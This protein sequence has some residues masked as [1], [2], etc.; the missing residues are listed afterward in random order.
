MAALAGV[1]FST[2][3]AVVQLG[4]YAGFAQ[5]CSAVITYAGGDL[6]V[7]ARG[8]PVF[9][10]GR[11]LPAGTRFIVAQHPCVAGVRAVALAWIDMQ[12]ATSPRLNT[13]VVGLDPSPERVLPWTLERGLPEDLLLPMRVSVDRFDLPKF[14][15]GA[16]PVGQPITIG[17]QPGRI[18]ALTSGIKTFTL[19]PYVFSS[20]QNVRA[21]AGMTSA[22]SQY[23]V[24][25]LK[26]DGCAGDVARWVERRQHLQARTAD[27]F[28]EESEAYWLDS[29]GAGLVLG[30]GTLLGLLVG[31]AIVAQTLYAMTR[32]HAKEL[33][34]LMALG[35]RRIELTSFVMWQAASLAL[36]GG[37][38]GL[39]CAYA[40]QAVCL[41]QGMNVVL[42][43]E[44]IATGLGAVF[45]ICAISSLLSVRTIFRL[46]PAMGFR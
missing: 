46:D 6:W 14:Q 29:S 18:A 20:V 44:V 13:F 35:A 17:G 22:Q 24:V 15:L 32:D 28:R 7:M 25:D 34:V 23:W 43:A 2:T 16:D 11:I 30:F 42:S 21:I 4:L 31:G 5:A 8:T 38:S 40:L 3:L 26:D 33:A 45:G 12:T 39:A 19:S 37:F 10:Y 27:A 9:D 36:V 1:M 41:R